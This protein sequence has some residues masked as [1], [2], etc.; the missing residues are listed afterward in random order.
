MFELCKQFNTLPYSGGMLDQP[1][2]LYLVFEMIQVAKYEREA[3]DAEKQEKEAKRNA[4]K[5]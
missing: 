5:R 2:K 3:R 1:F 4:R